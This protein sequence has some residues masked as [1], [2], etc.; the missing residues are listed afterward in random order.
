MASQRV[1]NTGIASLALGLLGL[2]AWHVQYP[3][4]VNELF[5]VSMHF[6]ILLGDLPVHDD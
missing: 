4:D 6:S 2:A 3:K 5:Q 1:I